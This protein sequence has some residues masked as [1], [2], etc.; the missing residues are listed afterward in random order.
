LVIIKD[1][2]IVGRVTNIFNDGGD[3]DSIDI[4]PELGFD[5]DPEIIYED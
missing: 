3:P 1:R 4:D 5:C 2:C